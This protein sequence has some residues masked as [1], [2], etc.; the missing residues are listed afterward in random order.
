LTKYLGESIR[1]GSGQHL[2]VTTKANS[3]KLVA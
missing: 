1:A 3:G 2:L